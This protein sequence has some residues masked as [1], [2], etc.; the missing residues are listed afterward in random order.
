[1]TT[2][3]LLDDEAGGWFIVLR[4]S[5]DGA[6]PGETRLDPDEIDAVMDAAKRLLGGV[7]DGR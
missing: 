3:V 6:K 1:M 5:S 7:S 4:Q 2:R